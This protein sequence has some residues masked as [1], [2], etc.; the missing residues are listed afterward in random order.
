MMQYAIIDIKRVT[1]PP[2]IN[3]IEPNISI[4]ILL[5][6]FKIIKL[7]EKYNSISPITPNSNQKNKAM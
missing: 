4:N 5:F 7:F 3:I 2:K 1:N 6:L